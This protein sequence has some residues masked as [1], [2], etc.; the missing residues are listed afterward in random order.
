MSR[1]QN[2]HDSKEAAFLSLSRRWKRARGAAMGFLLRLSSESGAPSDA[3][4][5][6]RLLI[7]PPRSP[8]R[9]T[10][11]IGHTSRVEPTD[12]PLVASAARALASEI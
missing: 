1:E 11:V 4:A 7:R 3:P 6:S 9:A 2:L 10:Q 12:V 5:R 8:R